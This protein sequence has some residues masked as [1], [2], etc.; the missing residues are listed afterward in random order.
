[1]PDV[2]PGRRPRVPR[3]PVRLRFDPPGREPGCYVECG[4]CGSFVGP[5]A[6]PSLAW[7]MWRQ[8][9]DDDAHRGQVVLRVET[10]GPERVVVKE[11]PVEKVVVQERVVYLF[12]Q[13]NQTFDGGEDFEAH[14]RE[15]AALLDQRV[16]SML[17][18]RIR[19]LGLQD[20]LRVR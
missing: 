8:G 20:R 6:S 11:V 17:E 2:I 7:A 5:A 19:A 3:A 16:R 15:C 14:R 12:H 10:P 18:E 1:M 4:R 9:H 13:C